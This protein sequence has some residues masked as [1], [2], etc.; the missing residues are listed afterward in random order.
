MTDES[1]AGAVALK[2]PF[3]LAFEFPNRSSIQG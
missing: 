2:S 3:I 1:E